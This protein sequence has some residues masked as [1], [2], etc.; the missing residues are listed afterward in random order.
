ML[1]VFNYIVIFQIID[2][3]KVTHMALDL[4]VNFDDKT[5][6]GCVVLSVEKVNHAS[7]CLVS[8]G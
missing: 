4:E 6:S 2:E 3:I 7:S 8:I 5:L 1:V